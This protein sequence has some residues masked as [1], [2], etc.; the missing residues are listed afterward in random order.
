MDAF[1]YSLEDTLLFSS[2][3]LIFHGS[4]SEASVLEDIG[5]LPPKVVSVPPQAVPAL[6][7]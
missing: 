7:A 5:T 6:L 1:W 2:G 4:M 3:S